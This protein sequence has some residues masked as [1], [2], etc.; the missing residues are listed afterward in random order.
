MEDDHVCVEYEYMS[1]RKDGEFYRECLG[2]E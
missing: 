2:R 1:M